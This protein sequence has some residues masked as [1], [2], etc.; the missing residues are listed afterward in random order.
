[1]A[2]VITKK[3][4]DEYEVEIEE[5]EPSPGEDAGI[6]YLFKIKGPADWFF[7][8]RISFSGTVLATEKSGKP[9]IEDHIEDALEEAKK[10]I[11][12]GFHED[13]KIIRIRDGYSDPEVPSVL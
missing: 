9:L 5:I 1:M 11:R 13:L 8:Y 2:E 6:V 4:T 7:T 12:Q 10:L 3:I